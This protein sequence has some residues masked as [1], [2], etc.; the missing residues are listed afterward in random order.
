[1]ANIK[2]TKTGKLTYLSS[3]SILNHERK[4]IRK[5]QIIFALFSILLILLTVLSLAINY[6]FQS[7]S[8]LV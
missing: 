1:M 7:I 8:S 6:K 3:E 2:A 4:K 5:M